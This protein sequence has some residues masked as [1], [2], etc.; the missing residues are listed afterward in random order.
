[1]L[2]AMFDLIDKTIEQL[3][4]KNPSFQY[5][6]N[7]VK[8]CLHELLQQ[9]NVEYIAIDSRIKS[10]ASLKEKII[11]NKYY[12]NCQKAE[13]VLLLL[14]DLIGITIACQ[15]ISEENQIYQ[16][17]LPFFTLG[18]DEF[19]RCHFDENLYLN[20]GAVQPQKQRNGFTLYR[21]DGY[22]LFNDKR[23]NFELQ[24][25]SLVHRFWSDIEHQVVYKNTSYIYNDSF[26]KQVLSSVHDSLEV[27]DHQ[28]QIG[29]NQIRRESLDNRDFGM[30]EKGFKMF[31]AKSISDL[32][33]QKMINSVGFTTDFKKCSAILSQ[34]IYIHDFIRNENPTLKMLEYFEH[35]NLLKECDLDFTRP[36][37]FDKDYEHEDAFCNILGKYWQSIINSDYEWHV[38]FIMMFAIEPNSSMQDFTQFIVVIKSMLIHRIWFDQCFS[39]LEVEKAEQLRESLSAQLAHSLVQIGRIEMIYEENLFLVLEAFTCFVEE[40]ENCILENSQVMMELDEILISLNAKILALF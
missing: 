27:V 31:L 9:S 8:T 1:M 26:M 30:S 33:T 36:I 29:S 34:F 12:L 22:Y 10:A 28:L 20:C 24:I 40:L 38:F 14:P 19:G 25:K 6:E 35:F 21:I 5:V 11:R 15:F 39:C 23:I 37:S 16:V 4:M 13:D 18:D 32:Y 3:E 7:M 17:I 2:L